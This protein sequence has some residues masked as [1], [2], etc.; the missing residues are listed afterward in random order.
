MEN[1]I[2]SIPTANRELFIEVLASSNPDLLNSLM[3]HAE[4]SSEEV[5][6]VQDILSL[7]FTACLEA[8]DEPTD[9]GKRIDDLIGAFVLKWLI[10]TDAD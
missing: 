8:N 5:R 3:G 4:P 6:M 7:E 1:V 2:D 10:N 9:R